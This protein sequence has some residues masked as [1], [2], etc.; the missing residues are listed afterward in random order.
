MARSVAT[1]GV[2]IGAGR[3]S[4]GRG[5][6]LAADVVA[7]SLHQPR[8]VVARIQS[9]RARGGGQSATIRCSSGCGSCRSRP[10]ISTSSSWSGSRAWSGRCSSGVVGDF[11]RRRDG[12]RAARAHRRA[13]RDPGRLAAGAVAGA[14]QGAGRRRH[15]HSRRRRPHAQG[16]RLAAGAL[17]A[18]R[19]PDPDAA[20]RRSGASLPVHPEPRLH[21]G[22]R[23]AQSR[24]TGGR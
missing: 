10:T 11:G 14:A 13:G 3:G 6:P 5:E 1:T 17:P 24:R 21:A 2:G 9:A 16:A 20:R 18:A 19:L 12:G 23:A 22:A 7:R 4:A 8:A 15:R